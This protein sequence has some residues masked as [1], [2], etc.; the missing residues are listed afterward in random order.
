MLTD[1]DKGQIIRRLATAFYVRRQ[2]GLVPAV[3]PALITRVG[4]LPLE[5]VVDIL[6]VIQNVRC[7]Y[8]AVETD[9]SSCAQM[10]V[11]NMP[12]K[13]VS[14]V[15]NFSTASALGIHQRAV[16][17]VAG[18]FLLPGTDAVAVQMQSVLAHFY[19]LVTEI[20]AQSLKKHNFYE[21][22]QRRLCISN[23]YSFQ[24]L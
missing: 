10:I 9:F 21:N 18:R 11:D 12:V 3:E 15:E 8:L 4:H 22:K 6:A 14:A 5:S 1:A 19:A 7:H 24:A 13:R 16:I 17:A 2:Y 20:A 23:Q